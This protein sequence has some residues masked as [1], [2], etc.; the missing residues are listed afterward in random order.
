VGL[1]S[2]KEESMVIIRNGLDSVTDQDGSTR[3]EPLV[4]SRLARGGKTTA[5]RTLF[6]EL[7]VRG[8]DGNGA[9]ARMEIESDA[10]HPILIT[11][12]GSSDFRRLKGETAS[13]A[14]LRLIAYQLLGGTRGDVICDRKQLDAHLGNARVVL[15]IDELNA[16]GT[17]DMEAADLLRDMFLDRL[18]RYLV[19][20]THV[21][22][23]LNNPD[24][25]LFIGSRSS[26]STRGCKVVPLPVTTDIV[27]LRGMH[28]DCTGMTPGE[29][30]YFGGIP[31]LVYSVKVSGE[32]SPES[33][34][35]VA[36]V[37]LGTK[38]Q[39]FKCLNDFAVE[40][41]H[42]T[43][44]SD[45]SLR[46]LD[47]FSSSPAPG[48]IQWAPCYMGS[49][50]TGF[51][52][53]LAPSI[54]KT[55]EELRVRNQT[56]NTGLEWE[57]ILQL[58][59]LFRLQTTQRGIIEDPVACGRNG[60]APFGFDSVLGTRR[61]RNVY[62]HPMPPNVVDLG[63][64]LND[65]RTFVDKHGLTDEKLPMLMLATPTFGAFPVYDG[66]VVC[67]MAKN[68]EMQVVGYQAKASKAF[69]TKKSS[70]Q[71]R[72]SVLLCGRAPNQFTKQNRIG[73]EYY[74]R[75]AMQTLLGYSLWPLCPIKWP[76]EETW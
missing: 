26:R 25:S 27:A 72:Q 44:T 55:V 16:L 39:S 45:S 68:E 60:Y 49:I 19:F 23:N 71:L 40:V 29:A 42:G 4:F 28:D 21:P 47:E 3:V 73:W 5:L 1:I 58:A 76:H 63:G 66:F 56:T 9:D 38:W 69:P 17:L 70:D 32:N 57:S 30:A 20:S 36:G 67:Q 15:M 22:I 41:L 31:S 14:I 7:K 46:L 33:R 6:D 59:L 18:N 51:A 62:N 61:V 48:F 11:F 12:N 64:A 35:A 53:G 54:A 74:N 13:E 50:C 8:H 43:P 37:T 75:D 2:F 10:V 24:A 34:F 65:M 52:M